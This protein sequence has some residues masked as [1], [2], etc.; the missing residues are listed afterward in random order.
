MNKDLLIKLGVGIAIVAII[1]VVFVLLNP[2]QSNQPSSSITSSDGNTVNTLSDQRNEVQQLSDELLGLLTSLEG[3][4]LDDAIFSNPA[5]AELRDITIPVPSD[6]VTGRQNPFAPLGAELQN[7]NTTQSGQLILPS[8]SN[9]DENTP[10]EDSE[11][12]EETLPDTT[13]S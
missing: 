11:S 12:A 9:T 4:R 13:A 5:Y 6:G 2:G 8:L 1:I 7:T 3:I 10:S